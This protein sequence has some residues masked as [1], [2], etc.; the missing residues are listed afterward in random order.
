M[1]RRVGGGK[2]LERDG[3]MNAEEEIKHKGEEEEKEWRST[4]VLRKDMSDLCLLAIK[5]HESVFSGYYEGLGGNI[6]LG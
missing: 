4:S 3:R 5:S 6:T 2:G 1:W